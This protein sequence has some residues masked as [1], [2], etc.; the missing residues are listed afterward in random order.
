MMRYAR[1]LAQAILPFVRFILFLTAVFLYIKSL[2][3][4]QVF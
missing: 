1:E 2:S 3:H 4:E